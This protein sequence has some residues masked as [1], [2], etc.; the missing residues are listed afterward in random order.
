MEF[1]E[2]LNYVLYIVLTVILPVVTTYIV[3]FIKAKIKESNVIEEKIK[4]EDVSN[5][6]KDALSNVM[7]AVL[8]VNQTYTDSLKAQGCF[9]K[10]AQEE[11]FDK[12]YEKAISLI[13]QGT[14]DTIEELYGSFEDWLE[15]KIES[16]VRIA[17]EQ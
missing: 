5:I 9:N 16:S 13:S 15:L 4:N 7:D 6:I 17:K 8:Y 3:N 12:A 10:E 14:K 1:S 2:V 11:A